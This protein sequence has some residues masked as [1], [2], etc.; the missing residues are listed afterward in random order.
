MPHHLFAGWKACLCDG[1]L[2]WHASSGVGFR[3]LLLLVVTGSR[4]TIQLL[5]WHLCRRSATR[6]HSQQPKPPTPRAKG[7]LAGGRM[8][9]PTGTVPGTCGSQC[10]SWDVDC[11]DASRLTS[12]PPQR[13]EWVGGARWMRGWVRSTA[14]CYSPPVSKW[15]PA[16]ARCNSCNAP[17]LALLPPASRALL[18]Q[19][20]PCYG[21]WS[22]PSRTT[23]TLRQTHP[24]TAHAVTQA[25]AH[26]VSQPVQRPSPSPRSASQAPTSLR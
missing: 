18:A 3:T 8:H 10:R 19:A 16:R 4:R 23:G 9:T 12:Q 20:A 24:L 5:L 15:C 21:K 11:C 17:C 1:N 14:S 2:P 6:L 26:Q 7:R 13:W 22:G 25:W